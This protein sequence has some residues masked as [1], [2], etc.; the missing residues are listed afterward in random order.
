MSALFLNLMTKNLFISKEFIGKKC[1]PFNLIIQVDL[2]NFKIAYYDYGMK[3]V[4]E[5]YINQPI[6]QLEHF[7]S[8]LDQNEE[9]Q[10]LFIENLKQQELFQYYGSKSL[11]DTFV[12]EELSVPVYTLYNLMRKLNQYEG[13]RYPF[14]NYHRMDTNDTAFDKAIQIRDIQ[15]IK[16]YLS[17]YIKHQDHHT[18][19]FVIDRNINS[20]LDMKINLREYLESNLCYVSAQ[21]KQP[22]SDQKI[23]IITSNFD[24]NLNI[25]QIQRKYDDIMDLENS[26]DPNKIKNILTENYIVNIPLSLS[27]PNFIQNLT[28]NGSIDIYETDLIQAVIDYK[29]DTFTKNYFRNHLFLFLIFLIF[30]VFDIYYFVIYRDHDADVIAQL[31]NLAQEQGI[32]EPIQSNINLEDWINEPRVQQVIVK[33]VCWTY[34]IFLTYYEIKSMILQGFFSYFSEF[35]NYGDFA[36]IIVYMTTSILDLSQNEPQYIRILYSIVLVLSF[37]KLIAYLRLYKGFSF[38]VSMIEAVFFDLKYFIALYTLVVVLYAMIFTLLLS[39]PGETPEEYKGINLMGYFI[40][41]FRTSMGDFQV[42]NYNS[43]N[44]ASTI[45]AWIIWLVGVLFLNIILLNFIIAVISESY[46]KIM[47]KME[48]QSYKQQAMLIKEREM[49]LSE[50]QKKSLKYFPK[51]LIV[52]RPIKN[53]F[54]EYSEWQGFL[55]NIKK[56]IQKQ[57]SII[58]HQLEQNQSKLIK[59]LKYEN[60]RQT[61]ENS[62]LKNAIIEV[63]KQQSQ[64][65]LNQEE[66]KKILIQMT[67]KQDAFNIK[68]FSKDVQT[69][70]DSNEYQRQA[71]TENQIAWNTNSIENNSQLI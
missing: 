3:K 28:I 61:Q 18:F 25:V 56:S 38:L 32:D 5:Y 41:S 13:F 14:V 70:C 62:D 36:I 65:L 9:S 53:E 6:C 51:Y 68:E 26:Q 52:R 69:Q 66:F 50:A 4:S 67:K 27:D 37:I 46:E 17:I 47:Q 48:A 2:Q 60:Q 29:W 49:H 54:E 8:N 22:F 10:K 58:H 19:N 55:K 16:L 44:S 24:Q 31:I 7:T 57:Q 59:D 45:F 30:V 35:F 39:K 20:L 64:Q 71:T 11:F 43:L 12:Q 21:S 40:M 34:L 23:E 15:S 63:Q 1:N 42:D 33:S